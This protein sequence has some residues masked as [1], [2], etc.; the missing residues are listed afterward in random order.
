MNSSE[1][2]E[3]YDL[4]IVRHGGGPKYNSQTDSLTSS[5][6]WEI[7]NPMGFESVLRIHGDINI[8]PRGHR[9]L[10]LSKQ[11]NIEYLLFSNDEYKAY[12]FY[13]NARLWPWLHQYGPS[14]DQPIFHIDIFNKENFDLY[15][16]INEQ[17][18]EKIIAHAKNNSVIWIHDYHLFL[19]PLYL[20][21]IA[22]REQINIDIRFFV[23]TPFPKNKILL[24]T[25]EIGLLFLS[26]SECTNIGFN[27][28]K[29]LDNFENFVN[30]L[31]EILSKL[32]SL[33]KEEMFP[34]LPILSKNPIGV[35]LAVDKRYEDFEA[36]NYGSI[37]KYLKNFKDQNE[38]NKIFLFIGRIDPIKGFVQLINA[39]RKILEENTGIAGHLL[40]IITAPLS[41]IDVPAYQQLANDYANYVYYINQLA[42]ILIG[43]NIIINFG[44]L[45]TNQLNTLRKFTDISLCT[46]LTDGFS[47]GAA[48]YLAAKKGHGDAAVILSQNAG[49]ADFLPMAHQFDPLCLAQLIQNI[50]LVATRNREQ[51]HNDTREIYWNFCSVNFCIQL[52]AQRALGRYPE[53]TVNLPPAHVRCFDITYR[54]C[55]EQRLIANSGELDVTRRNQARRTSGQ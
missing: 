5:N 4:I 49:C 10:E 24:T 52:W 6:S 9:K 27:S 32:D 31:I 35:N 51:E 20:K 48:E 29:S 43:R 54:L 2:L 50:L 7:P 3:K 28:K 1:I 40:F 47:L 26:L 13:C 30:E 23:H 22:Q 38:N 19:V 36:T 46:S 14:E 53:R 17:Y 55:A 11:N 41:R 34:N 12:N 37:E 33:K 21:L 25:E 45:S 16:K 42:Q 44:S 8:G 18:A 39:I 15:K